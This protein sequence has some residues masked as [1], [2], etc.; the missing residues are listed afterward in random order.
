MKSGSCQ[1]RRIILF[2]HRRIIHLLSTQII[3]HIPE[4][5]FIV[6]ST[7]KMKVADHKLKSIMNCKNIQ[8]VLPTLMHMAKLGS[9]SGDLVVAY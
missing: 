4:A 3:S 5:K 7:D 8:T 2:S 6:T 1:T 9:V